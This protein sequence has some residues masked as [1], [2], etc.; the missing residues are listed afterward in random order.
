MGLGVLLATLIALYGV[1][2]ASSGQAVCAYVKKT[3]PAS[4]RFRLQYKGFLHDHYLHLRQEADAYRRS[5]GRDPDSVT[6]ML[7]ARLAAILDAHARTALRDWR[8]VI[9]PEPPSCS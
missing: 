5:A 7:D 4:H 2:E 1:H 6:A 3:Y 9:L 8:R